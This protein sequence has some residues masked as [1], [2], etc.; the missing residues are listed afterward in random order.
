MGP[1]ELLEIG[2]L[3]N[4]VLL[5]LSSA[6]NMVPNPN[7]NPL[8]VVQKN[9]LQKGFFAELKM[10]RLL[11]KWL[12]QEP[13]FFAKPFW[14]T[15]YDAI[16][17]SSLGNFIS[18]KNRLSKYHYTGSLQ[19]LFLLTLFLIVPK[20]IFLLAFLWETFF[21]EPLAQKVLLWK[22]KWFCAALPWEN[23]IIKCVMMVGTQTSWITIRT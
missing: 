10:V 6:S 5:K 7:P 2:S 17:E 9:W 20:G 22:K 16:F 15:I 4:L 19:N 3:K 23:Y 21:E 18:L 12:L 1:E 11:Q 14:N 8:W 13:F